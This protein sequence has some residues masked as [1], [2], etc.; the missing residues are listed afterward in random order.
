MNDFLNYFA[1]LILI[2]FL[3]ES[4]KVLTTEP[5]D[6][7]HTDSQSQ[8]DDKSADHGGPNEPPKEKRGYVQQLVNNFTKFVRSRAEEGMRKI[9]RKHKEIIYSRK[10]TIILLP[11]KKKP[12]TYYLLI[13]HIDCHLNPKISISMKLTGECYNN[14]THLFMRFV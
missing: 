8:S 11:Y 3:S 5:E 12:R 13:R 7:L 14:K 2:L 6:L 4:T 9:F 10:K 1:V